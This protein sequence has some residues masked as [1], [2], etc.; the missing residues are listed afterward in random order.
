MIKPYSR[1]LAMA[2][3]SVYFSTLHSLHSLH[4][5]LK[6]G[7]ILRIGTLRM[8]NGFALLLHSSLTLKQECKRV[9]KVIAL[10]NLNC[11]Q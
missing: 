2:Y 11:S 7:T 9:Q 3:M 10:F 8:Q 5:Y 1:R 4:S 6:S